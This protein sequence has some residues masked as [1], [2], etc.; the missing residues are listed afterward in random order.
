MIRYRNKNYI[1]LK[2]KLYV[3]KLFYAN[4]EIGKKLV[5][6]KQIKSLNRS[7]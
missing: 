4:V 1:I 3:F 6:K 2:K 7:P 5:Q